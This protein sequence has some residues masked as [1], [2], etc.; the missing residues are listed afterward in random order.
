MDFTLFDG[1]VAIV[2]V[3]SAV[4]AFSR[5]FV[6]EALAIGGWIVAAIV[7][8]MFAA[9]ATPLV[10]EIPVIS[11]FLD[12]CAPATVAGFFVVFVAALVVF[13]LF[14]PLF[15]SLV[16]R[17]AFNAIDQGLGFLFG[18]LR[19]V[20]LVAVA[21][22]VYDFVTGSD[23][24]AVAMV[25]DSQTVQVFD[26]AKSRISGDIAD[27]QSAMDWLTVKFEELMAESCDIQPG[28]VDAITPETGTDS[29]N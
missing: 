19:G 8:Y 11:D 17:S 1:G 13:A 20:L 24:G 4:L 26:R 29:G 22:V 18:A 15:S 16:Q 6:R 9:Q 28:S 21:L 2:I 3:L 7:A 5:G 14:A 10:K 23:A 25:D 27:Q 12:N